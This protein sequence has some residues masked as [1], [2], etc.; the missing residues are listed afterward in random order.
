MVWGE[1][2]IVGKVCYRDGEEVRDISR[3]MMPAD[4]EASEE[5]LCWR[6]LVGYA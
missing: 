5:E 1:F 4:E 3:Y 2:W 6:T